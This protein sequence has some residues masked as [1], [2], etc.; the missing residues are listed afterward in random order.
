M[1]VFQKTLNRISVIFG[2]NEKNTHPAVVP[3]RGQKI[4]LMDLIAFPCIDLSDPMKATLFKQAI[5]EMEHRFTGVYGRI[6]ICTIRDIVNLAG[7]NLW[8]ESA[9]AYRWLDR[10][11][12]V[13]FENMHPDVARQ[14]PH[15]IN[16]VFA[17]GDYTYPWERA[18]N[19]G[20]KNCDPQSVE[21]GK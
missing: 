1:R 18:V 3:M 5:Y 12:C 11:H 8:G 21:E 9:D 7:I 20:V 17:G 16:M 15:R 4:N 19:A 13:A 2:F 10:L 6:D 14:V